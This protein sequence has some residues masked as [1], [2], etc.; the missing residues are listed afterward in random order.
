MWVYDDD[1]PL[2]SLI[3]QAVAEILAKRKEL[4]ATYFS[5]RERVTDTGTDATYPSLVVPTIAYQLAQNIPEVEACIAHTL[6]RHVSI[7]NLKVQDQVA[8]LV[9]EP[10]KHASESLEQ[11]P[12][13][14]SANVIV[15][16]ALDDCGNHDFQ[17]MF[18][19]EFL[20][21][22]ASIEAIP[23]SQRL[24]LLGRPTDHLRECFL[25]LPP[26]RILQ[27]PV[28]IQR[29][30]AREEEIHRREEKL[31]KGEEDLSKE[32]DHVKQEQEATQKAWKI[33]L[34][35]KKAEDE[36]RRRE[37][38]LQQQEEEF[39]Q[40]QDKLTQREELLLPREA[41]VDRKEKHVEKSM[42]EAQRRLNESRVR[43]DM[44]ERKEVQISD[45]EKELSVREDEHRIALQKFQVRASN[46]SGAVPLFLPT[47]C[48]SFFFFLN[49]SHLCGTGLVSHVKLKFI[50]ATTESSK[51]IAAVPAYSS[52]MGRKKVSLVH[53]LNTAAMIMELS[54]R[55]KIKLV[56][57][58]H[59]F[60]SCGLDITIYFGRLNFLTGL[61]NKFRGT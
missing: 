25:K 17:I 38:R 3:G 23:Y 50:L 37:E 5:P 35:A 51:S 1:R 21:G 58:C 49:D 34:Q 4:A 18:L 31:R 24:L 2:T 42:R 8:K 11:L 16:H 13:R 28:H 52:S 43:E 56:F 6:A 10:L 61:E 54:M 27:R 19:E 9:I 59:E 32:R 26:E 55:N 40:R 29:W 22:L 12:E 53:S 30:R 46:T 7:F 45:K 41:A 14:A 36:V 48:H 44:V 57:A 39:R 33:R 15:V 47:V 60:R 20:H